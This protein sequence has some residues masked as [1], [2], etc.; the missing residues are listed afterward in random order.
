MKFDDFATRVF[1]KTK[2]INAEVE[3]YKLRSE[4]KKI[5]V[6]QGEIDKF[7]FSES[8]GVS[9][10][11]I[12]DGRQGYAYAEAL[13][14]KSLDLI[15]EGALDNSKSVESEIKFLLPQVNEEY[16]YI[17]PK[18]DK[19]DSLTDKEKIALMIDLEGKT[20]SL[21][22]R[23]TAI[24]LCSY[25]EFRNERSIKN[26][27]GIDINYRG[28]GGFAYISVV[29]SENGDVKTGSSYTL[30]ADPSQID[31]E[32]LSKEAVDEAISMFGARP[33]K[34]GNYKVVMR[35]NVFTELL[36]SFIPVFSADDVQKG[37]SGLKGKLGEKVASSEITLVD[38]PSSIHTYTRT[39]F[40]DEGVATM[41]K[42]VIKN[43][44]L[45]TFLHNSKTAA[46]DGIASTGN[47]FRSS[48]KAAVGIK[49]VNFYLAQGNTVFDKMM[50][51][52]EGGLLITGVAGLHS[53]LDTVSGDFSIQAH[54]YKIKNGKRDA[55]VNEITISGNFF[56]LLQNIVS[57]GSDLRFG[58]P[59]DGH[60]GSPSVLV[61]SISISGI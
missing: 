50:T 17:E 21:D 57:V 10:R 51:S 47:G 35:N 11:T 31:I 5:D 58:I 46:V 42:E 27:N 44:V 24:Q 52:A 45:T 25:V 15:I 53:G 33:V 41:K 3:L 18:F 13:D 28:V 1:E 38:D 19:F 48:Y 4:T 9:L 59:G 37:L 61:K 43:G 29:A 34:S 26:S 6:F 12:I 36:E 40:D 55:P 30:F 8:T 20:L 32:N 54:G 60:F 22:E 16:N 56:D 14:D 49:P 2:S 23:M 7:S 39:P